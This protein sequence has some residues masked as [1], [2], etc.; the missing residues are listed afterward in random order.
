MKILSVKE[1]AGNH[2]YQANA[3]LRPKITVG[4]GL[5]W[6]LDDLVDDSIAATVPSLG[7]SATVA[8][9]EDGVTTILTAQTIGAGTLTLPDTAKIYGYIAVNRALTAAET[10]AVTAYLDAKRGA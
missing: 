10:V 7:T 4:S 1:I 5:Y 6:L 2:A 8:Y 3:G 9:A